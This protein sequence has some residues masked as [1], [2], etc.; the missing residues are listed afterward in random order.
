MDAATSAGQAWLVQMSAQMNAAGLEAPATIIADGKFH[1]VD[2]EKGEPGWYI[3]H[4][5]EHFINWTF[6]AWRTGTKHKGHTKLGKRLSRKDWL[7]YKKRLR[8]HRAAAEAEEARAH[9]EAAV[10]AHRQWEQAKPAPTQHGYLKV[11]QIE[12]CGAQFDGYSLVVPLHDI[13]GKLWSILKISPDGGKLH[14][15]GG[16][17]KD[18]FCLIGEVK[19]NEPICVCEGFATGASIHMASGYA[20]F[21]AGCARNLGRV[22]KALRKK[23][24]HAEIIICADDDWLTQ[25]NGASHNTGKIAGEEAAKAVNGVLVLPW[26]D[27]RYRPKKATDFNDTHCLYGIGEVS[28]AIRLAK[29]INEE[30]MQ[31]SENVQEAEAPRTAPEDHLP[32]IEF[33]SADETVEF[34]E[35]AL[36]L[37]LANRHANEWRHV[38]KWGWMHFCGGRWVLDESNL[39][40]TYTRKVCRHAALVAGDKKLAAASTVAAVERMTRYEE[41]FAMATDEWDRDPWLLNTPGG[42][43]D[44]K[45][46]FMRP[47]CRADYITKVTAVSPAN[48]GCPLFMQFLQKIAKDNAELVAFIQRSL[49]YAMTGITREHAL[50]FWYGDGSNGK[51]VLLSTMTGILSEYHTAAGMETFVE[52]H[53]DR[54]PTEL[55]SLRGA[56]IVTAVETEQGRCWAEAKIKA[57]TGGDPISARFMRQDPFTFIPQFKLIV[58]GN[59]KPSLRSV[60]EAIRRRLHLVPFTVKIPKEQQDKDLAEKLKAEWPAILAWL[61][62]GC[63][64]WQRIGLAPPTIVADAT[65]EYL[66]SQDSIA[67]WIEDRCIVDATAWTNV[68]ELFVSYSNWAQ[69]AGEHVGSQK[70]FKEALGKTGLVSFGRTKKGSG[71]TGLK[72]NPMRPAD[73]A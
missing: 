73:A 68:T 15:K 16:R 40:L 46:G 5:N 18:C 28:T 69:K 20:V 63:L 61:I 11:K 41:R 65:E 37:A 23:Y 31:A 13:D 22:A 34:S 44:L 35:D 52:T 49:G 57:L 10:E 14:Q 26:F 33:P 12:P 1:Q 60:D 67:L 47:H 50:L 70:Q 21:S 54:H 58:V 19:V 6:A 71:Y 42:T 4:V 25:V 43:V 27:E 66:A 2:P 51:S 36:S 53:G 8:E 38:Q 24:V 59:H 9:E 29:V 39:T 45:T 64:E 55:A 62:D 30:K 3:V 7:A 72:L 56:R 32:P 48:T 17:A